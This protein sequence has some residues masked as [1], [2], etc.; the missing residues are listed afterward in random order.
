[1]RPLIIYLWQ[2]ARYLSAMFF[3][4]QLFRDRV[5]L[6]RA[7]IGFCYRIVV[8]YVGQTHCC[9]Q[10]TGIARPIIKEKKTHD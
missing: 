4:G 2:S 9:M 8:G 10:L 6:G 1:M 5:I 3:V 7:R